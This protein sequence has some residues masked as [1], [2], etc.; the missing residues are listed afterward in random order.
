MCHGSGCKAYAH[1]ECTGCA[2]AAVL[3]AGR[4]AARPGDR[5]LRARPD[6]S[7]TAP[8][9]RQSLSFSVVLEDPYYL[10]A[11]GGKFA[12]GAFVAAIKKAVPAGESGLHVGE[13]AP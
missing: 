2:A 13:V 6:I 7:G 3:V 4:A 1:I 5:A 8:G 10:K 9:L 11:T 12:A